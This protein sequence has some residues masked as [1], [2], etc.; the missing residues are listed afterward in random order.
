MDRRFYTAESLEQEMRD[1]EARYGLASSDFYLAYESGQ[2]PA[3]VDWFD[4]SVWA[5]AIEEA[6]R[7]RAHPRSLQPVG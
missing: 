5:G 2:T 7:L 6:K 1:F 3:D 4:A